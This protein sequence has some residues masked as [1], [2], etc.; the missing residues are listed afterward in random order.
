MYISFYRL[1]KPDMQTLFRELCEEQILTQINPGEVKT[2]KKQRK[3]ETEVSDL[4]K[5]MEETTGKNIV[6]S[7]REIRL[8]RYLSLTEDEKEKLKGCYKVAKK[9][10]KLES[11]TKGESS[12][13]DEDDCDDEDDNNEEYPSLDSCTSDN[14]QLSKKIESPSLTESMKMVDEILSD[15][16]MDRFEKIDKLEAILSALPCSSN[17]LLNDHTTT[18]KCSMCLGELSQVK[19]ERLPLTETACQTMST[20]DIVI[21]RVFFIE[22]EKERTKLLNSPKK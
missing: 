4:R 8:L 15:G 3:I 10:E 2:R 16:R 14:S 18:N 11:I 22:D 19:V 6:L 7:N 5:R 13:D 1:I 12:D 17:Q 9:L 20:G 21:T